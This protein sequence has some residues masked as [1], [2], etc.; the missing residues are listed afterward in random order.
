MESNRTILAVLRALACWGLLCEIAAAQLLP[1]ATAPSWRKLGNESVGL[2]LAGPAGGSVDAVWFSPSGDRLYA[3]TGSGLVF[4]TADFSDWILSKT[5][6]APP[7]DST[8][9]IQTSP[10]G[11]YYALGQ[12]LEA[13]DDSGGTYVNLTSFHGNS[14]IGPHQRALAISPVDPRQIV[15]A[16]DLGVWRSVDSGL[17]WSS[18]N[19]DL[20]NLPMRRLLP[21]SAS[22]ALRAEVEGVGIVELPPAAAAAHA[23][24]IPSPKDPD[25]SQDATE[26]QRQKAAQSLGIEI[27]AF[28][29][30]PDIWFAGSIDGRLWSSS[31]HGSNWILST[32]PAGGR[33]EAIVTAGE[34]TNDTPHSALAVV[35]WPPGSP[36]NSPR[37]LRTISDGVSWDDVSSALPEGS[38]H[39][40]A[41]DAT[42]RVVYVAGDHGVFTA[43]V[44]LSSLDPVT[45]WRL[46]PGLPEARVMD[47]RLDPIRNILYAALDG[48]GLYSAPS[49]HKTSSIRV[50]NA[51]DQPAQAVAPGILLRVQGSGLSQVRSESG[52][53]ALVSSS[54]ASTQVQ[55][56]FEASGAMLALTVESSGGES[57][58]ALP[59]RQVAPSI[60]VDGDGLPILIDAA[61]GLTLDARNVAYPGAR[62]QVF[63]SG[64]GKVDPEWRAGVPAPDD[65]PTVTARVEARLN[66]VPVEVTRATLAPGYVGLYLVEVQL[67][68]L[69][70]AGAGDFSLQV[71]GEDSNHVKIVVSYQ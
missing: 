43:R 28:A 5:A 48:Y 46:V 14:I 44:D 68:G 33:I 63:A 38:L 49:P 24:W 47:V 18:L 17:S 71:N 55:V 39:G 3:R 56:P 13:S 54:P 67:P 4:E 42:A 31:D 15:V 58:L 51:A 29:K 12:D 45:S 32:R 26:T 21:K 25:A 57:R 20:P 34:T 2:N 10:D 16:N 8:A 64:L 6:T 50:L 9:K 62:I 11:R 19:E 66:D 52:D 59:M 36:A 7:L 35:S 60:L 69:L 37:L 40:V 30:A 27:T 61:S 41:V 23:N 65:P 53:L 22:G 1:A 70:N